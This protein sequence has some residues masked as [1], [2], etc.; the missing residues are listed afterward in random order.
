MW[1]PFCL[2]NSCKRTLA[3]V[4]TFRHKSSESARHNFTMSALSCATFSGLFWPPKE[5]RGEAKRWSHWTCSSIGTI[6][7]PMRINFVP[8][9]KCFCNNKNVLRAQSMVWHFV[10][11]HVRSST[12]FCVFLKIISSDD[13]LS[14]SK[15]VTINTI[16]KVVLTVYI[17][18]LLG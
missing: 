10:R 17:P 12:G 1:P 6:F 9:V 13:Y 5:A 11:H 8:D 16:N 14:W 7:Q 2:T 3:F 18:Y 15:Q 4:T